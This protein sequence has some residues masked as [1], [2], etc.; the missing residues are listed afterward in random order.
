MTEMNQ[1]W[2]VGA[3]PVGKPKP[4]DFL[5]REVPIPEPGEG[6]VLLQTLYLGIAP[7]MRMY[8]MGESAAGEKPLNIGDVIHGRGAAHGLADL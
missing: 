2:C 8:M 3:R 5:Y 7:V 4:T 1:Q 6:E